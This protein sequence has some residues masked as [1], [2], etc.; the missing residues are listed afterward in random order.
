M[1]ESWFHFAALGVFVLVGIAWGLVRCGV[2]GE[3]PTRI[4]SK[5]S[6]YKQP[7]SCAKLLGLGSVAWRKYFL[8]IG[9]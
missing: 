4:P 5:F 3:V 1:K 7:K 6:C 9:C 2:I 8:V